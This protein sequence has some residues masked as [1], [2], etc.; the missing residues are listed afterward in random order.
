VERENAELREKLTAMAEGQPRWP[1]PEG[2]AIAEV[3]DALTVLWRWFDAMHIGVL[4]FA[5]VWDAFLLVWYFAPNPTGDVIHYLFPIGHII[6]VEQRLSSSRTG[7]RETHVLCAIDRTGR[8]RTLVQG[9]LV[10]DANVARWLKVE[11][12]RRLKMFD[13]RAVVG[14]VR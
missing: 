3:G 4:M 9:R 1:M 2:F 5:V 8:Q 13:A 12:E 6:Y 14:S 7:T 10:K 11:L